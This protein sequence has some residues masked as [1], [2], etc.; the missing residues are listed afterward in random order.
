M[1]QCLPWMA[2]CL[3]SVQLLSAEAATSGFRAGAAT[4]NITPF[5]GGAVIGGFTHFPATGVHDE[6]H[7]R[8]LVVDDG[9]TKLALVVCDLLGVSHDVSNTARKLIAENTGLPPGNVLICAVHTHSACSALGQ[10]PLDEYHTFVAR[11]IADGVQTAHSRLRPAEMAFMTAEAP[12][13]VNNRRWVMKPG[14]APPNPFGKIDKVKMNPPGGS[15][16]LVEPAGP[17]DPTVSILAFLVSLSHGYLGY[18]PTPRHFPL[19][20]YETWFGTNRLEPEA[21]LKMLDAL[22][23]M[24]AELKK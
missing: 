9:K 16:D 18:L 4:S 13:H 23:E 10:A 8:C 24:A 12:E 20:G 11:R 22:L 7:A 5:L 21:S 14:T 17:T 3:V 15:P 6:L 19:G 1:K 2:C